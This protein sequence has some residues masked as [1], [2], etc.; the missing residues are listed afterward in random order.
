MK[1]EPLVSLENIKKYFP[2]E[3]QL[4]RR[5]KKVIKAVDGINLK[6]YP[7]ETVGLVG[8]SG[9]GKSTTGRILS[10]LSTPTKGTVYFKD[11]EISEYK[12]KKEV[13]E[14]IQMIFQDPYSSLNPRMSIRNIIAE[15]LILHKKGNKQEQDKRVDELLERVGLSSSHRDRYPVEFSGGQR[16]RIGI[17]RALALSPQLIVCDE[18]VSALDVSVQAQI[19]NLLKEIQKDTGVSYLFIAHGIQAVKHIS[20][21]IAVMYLGKI[22]EVSEKEALFNQP[23]HPYT[24]SLLSAVPQVNPDK[25]KGKRIILKGEL[26][27]PENPPT[28]CSFHTRCPVALDICKIDEPSLVS[29]SKETSVSCLLHGPR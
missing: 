19:L 25:T 7:G 15:P 8:E 10:G 9:C 5:N 17:A 13:G 23:Y 14:R 3:G 16:Q 1:K 27:S 6:I 22:I 29:I 11:K 20:H 2:V 26:P 18:P 21:R 4:L 12:N 28:G 24:Q